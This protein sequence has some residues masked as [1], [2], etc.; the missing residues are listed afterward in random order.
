M[1]SK[2]SVGTT[3][4]R[5]VTDKD[6]PGSIRTGVTKALLKE[7][8]LV[9][10]M[11]EEL[12]TGIGMKAQRMYDYAKSGAYVHGLPSGQFTTGADGLDQ[13]IAALES[14]EGRSVVIDYSRYGAPNNLHIGWLALMSSHGY[15]P[16]TNQL[17]GL[18]TAKGTPVYLEDMV[19]V[20][21]ASQVGKIE[22][23]SL[24]LWGF[25]PKAGYTPKRMTMTDASRA[26][27]KPTAVRMEEPGTIEYLLVE[28]G[29]MVGKVYTKAS[30]TIPVS[31]YDDN[32]DYFHV[33]YKVGSVVKYWIYRDGEGTFPDLDAVYDREPEPNGSYFPF[34]YFRYQKRSENS[35]KN[36][37]AYKTSK[38]LVGY[39]GMNY[40]QVADG[41]NA[42]PNI[43]DVEQALLMMAVPANTTHPLERRYLWTFFNNLFLASAPGTAFSSQT[44]AEINSTLTNVGGLTWDLATPTPGKI[45]QDTRFKMSIE[46]DGI[47]KRRV[48]GSIGPVGTYTSGFT[49]VSRLVDVQVQVVVNQ[50]VVLEPRTIDDPIKYHYY[51]RQVS[52]GFYDE[53]QVVKMRTR[54]YIIDGYTT[55][56]DE[57]GSILIIPLD[58]SI[59]KHFSVPDRETIYARSLH[60]VFNS[61]VIT[62]IKWY[63]TGLFQVIMVI[64]AL[65]IAYFTAGS[66]L[67]TLGALL[68]AGAYQAA[69]ILILTLVVEYIV[70]QYAF[71]LFVKLVGVDAAFIVAIVAMVVS[72]GLSINTGSVNGAPWASELLQL[73]SGITQAIGGQ[74]KLDYQNLLGEYQD[75]GLFKDSQTKLLDDAKA[76]LQNNTH[77]DPFVIFGESPQD[78]YNRTVHSGNI[79]VVG[80][81]AISSYVDMALALP[82]LKDTIGDA[83]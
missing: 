12:V 69:A 66:T 1:G 21:P 82:K 31:G 37:P 44:A 78:F 34:A 4:M 56:G 17:A 63:Q 3:I 83:I 55:V 41:I 15:N 65:V 60:Y 48:A 74:L 27:I 24:A 59:T 49:V 80:I 22:P 7:G 53:I 20:I 46:N 73:S 35:D 76:L 11:L 36:T 6:L 77:L 57:L 8:D 61:V 30:F 70:V 39:L 43:G 75:F 64:I 26:L 71:K 16:A 5:V 81:G 18:T 28:Y 67:S 9:D 47:F 32:A 2:T 33:R 14:I 72:A 40:D 13:V 23:T 25:A 54:F 29:W 79:G 62:H 45:I 58:H 68:A 50:D 52:T 51:R 19:V 10:Y 38:K 42:N